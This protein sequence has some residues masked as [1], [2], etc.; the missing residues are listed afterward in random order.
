ME[1]DSEDVPDEDETDLKPKQL[2]QQLAGSEET[3]KPEEKENS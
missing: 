2:D 1:E 3:T